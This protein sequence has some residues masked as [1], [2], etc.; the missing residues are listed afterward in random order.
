[1]EQ[2]LALLAVIILCDVSA[3][4]DEVGDYFATK[5]ETIKDMVYAY[6]LN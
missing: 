5:V 3:G 2:D 4:F 1:M 6:D